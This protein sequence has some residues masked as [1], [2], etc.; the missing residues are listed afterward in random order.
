MPF[1]PF[2]MGFGLAAKAAGDS[3]IGLVSFGVAQVLM[4]IEPGVR[5][6]TGSGDLHGWSHTVGGALG[7]AGVAT[8]GSKWLTSWLVR[9]WN[10]ESAHYGL[11]WLCVPTSTS[12]RDLGVGALVGT[13]SHVVLD[14]LIHAD[15]RPLAPFSSA[16]PLLGLVAHDTVYS[17]MVVLGVLGGLAWLIR[18]RLSGARMH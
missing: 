12:Y 9:R 15:M 6:L 4:D 5:M 17:S 13:L 16:N 14:S 8:A 10:A 2:H 3:R 7:V 18:R 11:K 1:T